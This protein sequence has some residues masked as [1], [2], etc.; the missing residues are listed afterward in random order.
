MAYYRHS[1]ASTTVSSHRYD[2]FLT[3]VCTEGRLWRGGGWVEVAGSLSQL[4]VLSKWPPADEHFFLHHRPPNIKARAH[5]T[6]PPSPPS[7]AGSAET[8]EAFS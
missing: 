4:Q 5:P 7:L 6:P 1:T 8:N 3:R 2:L